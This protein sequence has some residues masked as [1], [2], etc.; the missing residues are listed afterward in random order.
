MIDF[1]SD[2]IISVDNL[3]TD[4]NVEAIDLRDLYRKLRNAYDV[5]GVRLA[6]R[7]QPFIHFSIKDINTGK[8]YFVQIPHELLV[9]DEYTFKKFVS[10]FKPERT[11]IPI[12]KARKSPST[13]WQDLV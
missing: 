13:D 2:F 9:H 3:N 11:P 1:P 6:Y 4:L 12:I 10:D 8:K 7:H 5:C